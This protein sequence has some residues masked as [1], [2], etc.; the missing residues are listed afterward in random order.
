MELSIRLQAVADAV[1]AGKK[2]ADIGCDHGYVSLYLVREK[3]CAKVIAMDLRKG[4]LERAGANIERYGLS[5]YIETRLSDGMEALKE[6]EAD[7]LILSGMGGRLC[8]RILQTGFSRLG[9]E[10]EL[11]LQPQSDIELVREFL[12]QQE[13]EIA[14]ENMVI[15]EGKFYTVIKACP[16]RSFKKDGSE[17]EKAPYGQVVEDY[18]GPILL[19]KRPAVF[20]SF[21]EREKK[22]T[23][24]LLMQ[25]TKKERV[26]ELKEYLSFVQEAMEDRRYP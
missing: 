12:R 17:P 16:A 21:L 1:S 23:E 18:F 26:A 4:P 25:V 6:G 7:A 20:L 24:M 3:R 5:D 15:D 22:K 13:F 9:K 10:F 14:D 19:R 8:I 11:V 2:P